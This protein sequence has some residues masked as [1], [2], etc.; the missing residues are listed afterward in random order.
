M[1]KFHTVIAPIVAGLSQNPVSTAALQSEGPMTG[2]R[3]GALN[4]VYKRQPI[5]RVVRKNTAGSACQTDCRTVK[6]SCG[7]SPDEQLFLIVH[8]PGHHSGSCKMENYD[9]YL[10]AIAIGAK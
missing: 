7:Y 6:V 2:K 3:R 1:L 9:Q 8:P 4:S 10:E 5:A